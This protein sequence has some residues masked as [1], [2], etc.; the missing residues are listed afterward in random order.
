[1]I[2][3]GA[4]DESKE[5]VTAAA[6]SNTNKTNQNK[7]LRF[8]AINWDELI[9]KQITAPWSPD[10]TDPLDASNF[11]EYDEDDYVVEEYIDTGD[12]WDDEF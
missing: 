11:D 8:N 10:I 5:R 1:M 9:A 7:T 6:A 3:D 4:S 12:G 2:V